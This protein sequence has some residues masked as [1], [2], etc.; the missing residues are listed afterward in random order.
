ME[1]NDILDQ[2]FKEPGQERIEI[3]LLSPTKFIFLD[4]LS[5]GLYSTWWTY[6]AWCFFQRRDQLDI[7]PAFRAIIYIFYLHALLEKIQINA[8]KLAYTPSFSSVKT[9]ILILFLEL[10]GWLPDPWWLVSFVSFLPY[11]KPLGA[12]NDIIEHDNFSQ[13]KV[14]NEFNVPQLIFIL[15]GLLFWGVISLGYFF[16][17]APEL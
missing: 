1:A 14:T 6:K 4:V 7:N 3:E 12:F 17:V 8:K 11:L 5:F 16:P 9:F 13:V 2:N 15:I 10:F